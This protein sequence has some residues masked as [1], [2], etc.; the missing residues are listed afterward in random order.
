MNKVSVIILTYNFDKFVQETIDS[1]LRQTYKNIEIIISDDG[2]T[3]KTPEIL[4]DYANKYPKLIKLVLN[5]V[6][7]GVAFNFNQAYL[8]ATGEYLATLS[9]DDLMYPDKLKKQVDLMEHNDNCVVCHHDAIVFDSTT[10]EKKGLFSQIYGPGKN[11]KAKG[12][13]KLKFDPGARMLPSTFMYRKIACPATGHDERL[14][15][16]AEMAFDVEV[17]LKGNICYIDEA[18][19]AYRRHDKNITNI[20]ATNISMGLEN[21][22]LALAL[23]GTRYPNLHSIVRKTRKFFLLKAAAKALKLGNRELAKKYSKLLIF[24][25]AIVRGIAMFLLSKSVNAK[26]FRRVMTTENIAKFRR[27]YR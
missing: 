10:K 6:N 22:M 20:L 13:F 19:G 5:K 21:E 27:I 15:V 2:S 23:L 1:V 8:I 25:G 7:S 16:M 24:E 3:D 18:L 14:G 9:G 12:D 11:I 4:L 17:A 26:W